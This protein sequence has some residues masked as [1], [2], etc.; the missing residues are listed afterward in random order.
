MEP[1]VARMVQDE[2]SLRPTMKEVMTSFNDILRGL[3][4]WKLRLRLVE[5]KDNFAMNFFKSV[6]HVATRTAPFVWKGHPA[7][8]T[9]KA[10]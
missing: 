10:Q 2:P 8:P 7:I 6:H 3:S 5:R 9:P 1:L 4:G